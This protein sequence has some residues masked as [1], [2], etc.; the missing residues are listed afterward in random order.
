MSASTLVCQADN[1]LSALSLKN[2]K[3]KWHS[4]DYIFCRNRKQ[5]VLLTNDGLSI[6]F[7]HCNTI[8]VI[9][10]FKSV[11]YVHSHV[12]HWELKKWVKLRTIACGCICQNDKIEKNKWIGWQ[13]TDMNHYFNGDTLSNAHKG[14]KVWKL[15]HLGALIFIKGHT[16]SCITIFSNWARLKWKNF[17]PMH[18]I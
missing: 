4:G 2:V 7:A 15:V 10:V 12:S 18:T 14:F 1:F 16:F 13:L 9:L 5:F 11:T 8:Q 17:L 6:V 3:E